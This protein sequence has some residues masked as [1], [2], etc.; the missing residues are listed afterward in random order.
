MAMG[1]IYSFMGNTS[2]RVGEAAYPFQ[3]LVPPSGFEFYV[4][5]FGHFGISR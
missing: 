4:L 5:G 2:F 1:Y 3:V